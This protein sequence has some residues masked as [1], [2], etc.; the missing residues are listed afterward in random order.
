MTSD[1]S[2]VV[3]STCRSCGWDELELVVAFGSTPLAD[4]LVRADRLDEPQPH[5]PLTLVVCP[6]CGLVQISETVDPEVLF[7][8]EYPYFSS[9]SPRLIAHF[10]ASAKSIIESRDWGDNPLAVE[11]ASNDGCLLVHFADAG[12][13]VLGVDP[14]AAPA[15][16]AI[17][18][19]VPT[20]LEFF[21]SRTAAKITEAQGRASL[22]LGNNVLAHVADL[23]DF[24]SGI[25]TVLDD[26]GLA[27]IECPYVVDLVD[28]CEFDT[29]YHQHL[30][31]FS[32]TALV[33][34]FARHS[35]HLNRVERTSIHGG[36][37]R[38]FIEP[39][40]NRDRSVDELLAM[41]TER[42]FDG[43]EAFRTFATRI[44]SLRTE[45][46][47]IIDDVQAEGGSLVGYAAAA[48]GTTLLAYCGI[49]AEDLTYICD[50]NEY[51]Q[52]R[53]MG[54]NLIPIVSPRRL[55]ADQPDYVLIL[56][57]NFAAEIM[58]QN[59]DYMAAGG[60]FIVPVPEPRIVN[61]GA[62]QT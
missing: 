56:A 34:L 55:L 46:R 58:E 14:S 40:L 22:F 24:V 45:L 32:I 1:P 12:W 49:D 62:G 6:S 44:D 15:Q 42:S 25:A 7:N 50:L 37:L 21:G 39:T 18:R 53:H 43:P 17:D 48:K 47:A 29:V 16:A 11:A 5:A 20:Q 59:A 10:G 51:K 33:P 8:D 38:L 35:L 27:V 57:W 26:D 19:G 41:E 4:R 52:G 36:S 61:G 28:H 30:C 13:R 3:E 31:Y 54:G 2:V 60:K 9:V 23:N